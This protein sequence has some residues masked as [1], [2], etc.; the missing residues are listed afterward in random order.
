MACWRARLSVSKASHHRRKQVTVCI[1]RFAALCKAFGACKRVQDECKRRGGVTLQHQDVPTVTHRMSVIRVL[2]AVH[3]ASA[4][5][6]FSCPRCINFVVPSSVCSYYIDMYR[7]TGN[8]RDNH[9]AKTNERTK[10]HRA[11]QFNHNA[12]RLYGTRY[13]HK[14]KGKSMARTRKSKRAGKLE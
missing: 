7:A 12:I 6:A 1:S 14:L 11:P 3:E 5:T 9:G 4:C 8:M 10:R 2:T 13:V